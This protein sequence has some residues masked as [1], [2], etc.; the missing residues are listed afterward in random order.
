MYITGKSGE[1]VEVSD[2][3]QLVTKSTVE[4]EIVYESERNATAYCW[5]ASVDLGADKNV[6][7]LR[8]DSRTHFLAID[9]VIMYASASSPMEIWVGTG[10][11]AG[12]TVV[13]GVNLHVGSGNIA[14]ATCRHTNTNVDEGQGM[15][16]LSTHQVGATNEE[17][18]EYGG[19][20]MLDYLQEVAV[21]V[22]TDIVLSSVNIIGW[23]NERIYV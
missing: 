20:L 16:L 3:G 6:I 4:N 23:L 10:N 15:T 9:R 8:N 19:A 5:A 2:Y 17:S 12:G 7:W 13:T 18:V 22:I 21:N 11:T 1:I 14:D